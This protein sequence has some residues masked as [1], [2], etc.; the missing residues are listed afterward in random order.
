M[1]LCC[2]CVARRSQPIA[3]FVVNNIINEQIHSFELFL[4]LLCLFI[5]HTYIGT[6]GDSWFNTLNGWRWWWQWWWSLIYRY[7]KNSH[8]ELVIK[9]R[10]SCRN[11]ECKFL[12]AN[13]LRTT[14]SLSCFI[15]FSILGFK[16]SA[17]Y[18]IDERFAK[19]S[20]WHSRAVKL[21]KVIRIS[22]LIVE[23]K[24]N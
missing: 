23:E 11:C 5:R 3:L 8:V 13:N 16:L 20:L 18:F 9:H 4:L 21:E 2:W 1:S 22:L 7:L 24:S 14:L 6:Y 15:W 17:P 19:K 12:I 10:T